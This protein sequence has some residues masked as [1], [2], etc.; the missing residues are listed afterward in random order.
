MIMDIVKKDLISNDYPATFVYS[1]INKMSRTRDL[2]RRSDLKPL[3]VV[4]VPYIRGVSENLK[5][6]SEC[7]SIN[8]IFK[9]THAYGRHLSKT[10]P[11]NDVQER[12]QCVY[13]IHRECL[14]LYIGEV[15]MPLALRLR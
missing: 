4:S 8:A 11:I 10:K 14:E 9:T 15:G 1:V 5:R 12:T 6:I 13:K 2:D 7:Y 3:C